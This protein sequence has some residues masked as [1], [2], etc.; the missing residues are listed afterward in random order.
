[1]PQSNVADYPPIGEARIFQFGPCFGPS[2]LNYRNPLHPAGS[3]NPA[4][5]S[6]ED[7]NGSVIGLV[8]ADAF[9]DSNGDTVIMFADGSWLAVRTGQIA[10]YGVG[11]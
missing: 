9:K 10:H 1:M 11:E 4:I 6:F 3:S 7:S 5:N 8:V 2:D